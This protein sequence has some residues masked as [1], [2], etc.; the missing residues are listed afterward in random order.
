M[1]FRKLERIDPVETCCFFTV[2]VSVAPG[3]G[4]F[5]LKHFSIITLGKSWIWRSGGNI[6]INH[7]E[8]PVQQYGCFLKWWV[9]LPPN[10]P[11]GHRLFHYFGV[12]SPY[13]RKQPYG[14]DISFWWKTVFRKTH[15]IWSFH[16]SGMTCHKKH[17]EC[18]DL[19]WVFPKIVVPQNG[20]WK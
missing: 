13:F 10:H 14:D 20:W 17:G 2:V 12:F 7:R 16:I 5:V 9:L 11:F 15:N 3:R 18:I 4:W 1:F 19:I 8:P 6:H